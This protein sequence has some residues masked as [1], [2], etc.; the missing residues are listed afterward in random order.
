MRRLLLVILIF[1]S[2]TSAVA[3]DAE[4]QHRLSNLK[5]NQAQTQALLNQLGG[6]SSPKTT[7]GHEEEDER[8]Q[9]PL[10]RVHAEL[11]ANR[12]R[13][14][15]VYHAFNQNRLVIGGES[16]PA[17]LEITGEQGNLSGLR[18]IANARPSG[19]DG[20]IHL[21]VTRL[22]LRSGRVVNIS[23]VALDPSGSQGL[24][25]HVFSGKALAVIGSIASSFV[26]GVAAS[27]QTQTS[28]VF[29]FT[30]NQTT[31][32]NAILGG[33]AQTAADQSKRLIDEATSEKPVL[34]LD[35]LTPIAVFFQEEVKF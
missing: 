17:I 10:F 12:I 24:P 15:S 27:Q 4:Y 26:A 14:G 6:F 35:E 19:T 20:R 16:S 31:G 34:V 30:Q 28:N 29:G 7:S 32:R 25:A 22:L 1:A 11:R 3:E 33:V 2:F 18:L 23:A 13:T 21:E 5:A 9:R 8:S